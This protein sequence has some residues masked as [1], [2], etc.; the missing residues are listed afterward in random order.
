[1]VKIKILVKKEIVD[2]L[3][4]KKTLITMVVVPVLL[5]PLLI[6]GLTLGLSYYMQ[7]EESAYTAGYPAE[8]ASLAKALE[9]AQ[10]EQQ[11]DEGSETGRAL[12]FVEVADAA[13]GETA[14]VTE[15]ADIDTDTDVYFDAETNETGTLTVHIYY[16]STDTA[17]SEAVDALETL[18]AK[19]RETL[20]VEALTAQGLS[21]QT[22]YPV[23]YERQDLSSVS[24]SIGIGIGGSIGMLLI[25]TILLGAFYPAI[26]ATAGERERGTLETLLTLP[27]TNFQMIM[28]KY[29]SVAIFACVTAVIS[30]VSLGGSVLFLIFGIAPEA[31]EELVD[32][33]MSTLLPVI[34][35]VV[36]MMLTTALLLTAFC[37]CF[38]VFARSFKE[39]NNYMTP[40]MLVVMLVSMVG[41]LPSVTLDYRTALIPVANTALMIKTL[42]GG[43]YDLALSVLT[44]AV[45]LSY[46]ILIIWILSKLYNSEAILFSDGFRS[47]RMFRKRSEIKKGTVPAP[48]DLAVSTIVLLLLMLYIGTA[49]SVRSVFAGTLVSQLLILAVPLLVAWYMKSDMKTL[50]ML[51]KPR[52]SALPGSVLLY[53]G[54]YCIGIAL[55]MA[56]LPLLPESMATL[57][58][59]YDELLSQ[60]VILIL[61]VTALMPAVGEELFFRGF[62]YGSLRECFQNKKVIAILFSALVFA[63]FHTSLIKLIPTFLLGAAFAYADSVGGSIF[64]SMTLHFLNNAFSMIASKYPEQAARLVPILTKETYSWTELAML[65]AVGILCG[66]AGF[67]L[68]RRADKE[69][70]GRLTE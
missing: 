1:M 34:P 57:E 42:I 32:F 70:R 55:A 63:A 14:D 8:C 21:E 38:C 33:R 30:L 25:V 10:E 39:A 56:L 27:V 12:Q 7:S 59:A 65:L 17:S 29:I 3:R 67:Y 48:G 22:L 50:F 68:L 36:L 31:M 5:Y 37:M 11:S 16:S 19:Y 66:A 61:L 62:F 64:I 51:R 44:I 54:A 2:I 28:S 46:S 45:N 18:L 69:G 49:V 53:V 4:D 47:V 43:Q 23:S 9:A 35:A 26:D 20:V 58:T 40:A 52:I 13:P 60:S 15:T 24:E 6:I 41:M